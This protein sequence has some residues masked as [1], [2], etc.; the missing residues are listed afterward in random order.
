[1][2][3][4]ARFIIH[5]LEKSFDINHNALGGSAV[6]EHGGDL[7]LLTVLINRSDLAARASP[8]CESAILPAHNRVKISCTGNIAASQCA[9]AP[10]GGLPLE[11]HYCVLLILMVLMNQSEAKGGLSSQCKEVFYRA[12]IHHRP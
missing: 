11:E 8:G 7:L 12:I 6:E 9:P 4:T 10:S 2:E 5:A 1:M 3:D